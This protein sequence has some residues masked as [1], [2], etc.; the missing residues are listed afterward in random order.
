MC[1][2]QTVSTQLATIACILQAVFTWQVD[3]DVDDRKVCS[4]KLEDSLLTW[5]V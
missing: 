5:N 2:F 1:L 3:G 4:L